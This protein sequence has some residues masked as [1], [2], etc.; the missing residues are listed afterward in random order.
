[1]DRY[2]RYCTLYPPEKQSNLFTDSFKSGLLREK[3]KNP[4]DPDL[5]ENPQF[6]EALDELN[7]IMYLDVRTYLV[8]DLLFLAD[9][10]SMAHSLELRVPFLDPG[11]VTYSLGIPSGMK[12]KGLQ[13]KAILQKAFKDW[14]PP[15]I[16]QRKKIGFM[17]PIEKWL[18]QD[19]KGTVEDLLSP[20]RVRHRGFF[21][22]AFIQH[23][24]ASH[25]SQKEDYSQH[26][27]S[28]MMLE[29]WMQ[30]FQDGKL[31]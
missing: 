27:F 26:I 24:L 31:K 9:K 29:L 17:A 7:K 25:K 6:P 5:F 22:P 11:L 3:Q 18:R 16:F 8:D 28:L 14:I 2:L 4:A 10:A 20:E 21:D 15:E 13:R 30:I 19:L 23:L 12:I 1:M